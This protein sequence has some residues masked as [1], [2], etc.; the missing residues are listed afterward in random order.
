MSD[1]MLC[2]RERN[3]RGMSYTDYIFI[4]FIHYVSFFLEGFKKLRRREAG[5]RADGWTDKPI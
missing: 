2:L 1:I 4:C 3:N 5:G